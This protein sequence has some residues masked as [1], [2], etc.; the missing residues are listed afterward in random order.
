MS[1]LSEAA[2]SD[3][4]ATQRY[5][6][7]LT[8]LSVTDS[9]NDDARAAALNGAPDGHVVLADHQRAG[10][11]A[12][13]AA[14]TSPAGTDLYLSIVCRAPVPLSSL[15]PLTLAVGLGVAHT[16][17]ERIDGETQLKW[18]NDVHIDGKK[19]AGVLIESLSVGDHVES[20]VIGIGL[21]VNRPAFG[22][23]LASIA[24]SLHLATGADHDRSQVCASLLGHVE[25]WV[26]R[27]V[28]EGTAGVVPAVQARLAWRGRI[29]DAGGRI[30]VL[31]G[32][33]PDGSL[34]IRDGEQTVSVC[35]G[36][37]RVA[38]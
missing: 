2:I 4:L 30:G 36:T 15:A 20:L 3:A 9:T 8:V 32:L 19:C 23:G 21:D 24:T 12:R 37:L 25:R 18:P 33:G 5:G 17:D 11:G 28:A 6:R 13:G 7:S 14:W 1:E 34:L 22:P 26:D 38:D 10:R 31:A 35:S 27:F 29:V 16:V